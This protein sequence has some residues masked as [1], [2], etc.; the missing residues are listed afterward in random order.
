MCEDIS[1]EKRSR[2]EI[3][4]KSKPTPGTIDSIQAGAHRPDVPRYLKVLYNNML[5]RV[6]TEPN[7]KDVPID[8]EWLESRDAFYDYVLQ[9]LGERHTPFHSFDRYPVPERGYVKGNVRWADKSQ[10]A[11]SR[12]TSVKV[13]VNAYLTRKLGEPYTVERLAKDIRRMPKI[14]KLEDK[15]TVAIATLVQAEEAEKANVD[16]RIDSGDWN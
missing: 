12:S 9:N 6:E 1:C 4:M 14:W 3:R 2:T 10:Q 15:L 16:S 11:Q 7:Y 13:K 5:R 8:P